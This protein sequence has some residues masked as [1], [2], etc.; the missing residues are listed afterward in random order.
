MSLPHFMH[1]DEALRTS[2]QD[3]TLTPSATIAQ[4]RALLCHQLRQLE[5][6]GGA[7]RMAPLMLWGAPGVGKSTVIRELCAQEGIGFIDIRL[8]QREPVDLRGLPVPQG[9]QVRWLL[10]SE[11]PRD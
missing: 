10:S 3:A 11:W 9:D 5:Q 6:P 4:V 8:S 7:E 1:E 2:R